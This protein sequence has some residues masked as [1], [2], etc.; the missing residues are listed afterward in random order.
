[1]LGD[2]KSD[3]SCQFVAVAFNEVVESLF[4]VELRIEVFGF[5]RVSDGSR[6]SFLRFLS[7]FGL[8][9]LGVDD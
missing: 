7:L 4:G 2:I 6:E 9:V 8:V 5:F 3:G 1:M